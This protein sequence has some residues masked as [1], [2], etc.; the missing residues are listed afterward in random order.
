MID[1]LPPEVIALVMQWVLR[2]RF[3]M[4]VLGALAST[5]KVLRDAV[6]GV[7]RRVAVPSGSCHRLV[8]VIRLC[9]DHYYTSSGGRQQRA[10]APYQAELEADVC[11]ALPVALCP[12]QFPCDSVCKRTSCGCQI[13]GWV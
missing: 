5:N 4:D 10:R 11:Q 12:Y 6:R 2:E 1:D 13:D 8:P 3:A 9:H 7:V